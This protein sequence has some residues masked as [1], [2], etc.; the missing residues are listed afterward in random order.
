MPK[1]PP[2]SAAGKKVVYLTFDDGPSIHLKQF[3]EVLEK[4]KAPASF[5]SL[6]T[7]LQMLIRKHSKM[8]SG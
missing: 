1:N 7:R 4:E 5:S 8:I 3:L 2:G 6:E